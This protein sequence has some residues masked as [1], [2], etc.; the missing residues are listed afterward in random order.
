[1]VFSTITGLLLPQEYNYW[2]GKTMKFSVYDR[3]NFSLCIH[4]DGTEGT[5]GRLP[6]NLLSFLP[7]AVP[8]PHCDIT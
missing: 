2:Q 8:N 5:V 1:M 6:E 7:L 3:Y 4:G